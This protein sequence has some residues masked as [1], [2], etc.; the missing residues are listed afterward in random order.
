[1]RKDIYPAYFVYILGV[2]K[3]QSALVIVLPGPARINEW[4][5]ADMFI[6]VTTAPLSDAIMGDW[7]VIG[8]HIWVHMLFVGFIGGSWALRPAGRIIVR[9]WHGFSLKRRL[10]WFRRTERSL[11]TATAHLRLMN[12][13]F[14][15]R[16]KTTLNCRDWG[17][18]LSKT[19]LDHWHR[20]ALDFDTRRSHPP[21]ANQCS[22]C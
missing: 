2:W 5:Y 15:G 12:G 9:P 20:S 22:E 21:H 6:N 3:V 18:K 11:A 17:A 13:S 8:F 1:M 4:A 10:R 19:T 14:R 7:G 16:I